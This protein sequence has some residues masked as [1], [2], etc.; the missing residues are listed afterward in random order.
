MHIELSTST[1][2]TP[3][4][5]PTPI[6]FHPSLSLYEKEVKPGS[7]VYEYLDCSLDTFMKHFPM[8]P[9]DSLRTSSSK[10]ICKFFRGPLFLNH[11]DLQTTFEPDLQNE[12]VFMRNDLKFSWRMIK[13]VTYIVRLIG[14][15]PVFQ[16]LDSDVQP[17]NSEL[18]LW[19][20][21]CHRIMIST[22][23]NEALVF[24]PKYDYRFKFNNRREMEELVDHL[25]DTQLEMQGFPDETDYFEK[26]FRF[27]TFSEYTDSHFFYDSDSEEPCDSEES[28]SETESEDDSDTLECI[29]KMKRKEKKLRDRTISLEN[30]ILKI[31][32][33]IT[34]IY[35]EREKLKKKIKKEQIKM[36]K[37]KKKKDMKRTGKRDT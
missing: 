13:Y 28:E 10:K 36:K 19:W 6:T 30:E 14:I 12:V 3:S 16:K 26:G 4:S 25:A 5:D 27:P 2:P 32:D 1:P 7:N 15:V 18:C 22:T 23:Y 33:E 34:D 29:S 31:E 8:I 11:H 35:F 21:G 24:F 17:R 9:R 37:E 20:T